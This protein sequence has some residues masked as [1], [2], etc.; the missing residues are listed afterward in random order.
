MNKVI[1]DICGTSYPESSDRC[2]ICGCSRELQQF[3]LSSASNGTEGSS[4]GG[5][6]RV[7][8]GR[9]ST[10]NVRKRNQNVNTYQVKQEQSGAFAEEDEPNGDSNK[11]LVALLSIL[12]VI[13]LVIAGFIFTR[14]FL[15]DLFPGE[16]ETEP[17]TSEATTEQTQPTTEE[18]TEPPTVPCESL[19]LLSGETAELYGI[20]QYYLV[21]VEFLPVD[22][23]DE[24]VYSSSDE[25]VAVVNGEGRVE[26]VGEGVVTI[27]VTCG[28]QQ[29]TC[30]LSCFA[31]EPTEETTEEP[32]E[33]TTEPL[34]DIELYLDKSDFTLAYRG[35]FYQLKFNPEL[36]AEDITWISNNPNVATVENGLVKCVGYGTTTVIAKYGDQEVECIVRCAW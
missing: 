11:L 1:C 16:E 24:L 33:E 27:T 31:Q 6:T 34:L 3:T 9:F 12:I 15:P 30:T 22:T 20:G 8:G 4:S 13:L 25:T 19:E 2:P 23:T 14:Y 17:S 32:T 26:V 35:D 18:I 29:V 10:A 5:K 36:T 21:N 28:P 7:K